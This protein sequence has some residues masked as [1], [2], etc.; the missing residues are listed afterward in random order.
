M[1]GITKTIKNKT[2]EQKGEFLGMLLGTLGASLLRNMLT[3]KGMLRAVYGSSIKKKF[4]STLFFNK[5]TN[6]EVLSE[7]TKIKGAYSRNNLPKTIKRWD[8]CNKS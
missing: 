6:T 7:K 1:K 3:G 4:N 5:F 8:I 2:K